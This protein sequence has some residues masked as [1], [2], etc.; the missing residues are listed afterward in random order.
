MKKEPLLC[1]FGSC[2][3]SPECTGPCAL[4]RVNTECLSTGQCVT[5]GIDRTED[6]PPHLTSEEVGF[7]ATVGL[8]CVIFALA[9][10]CALFLIV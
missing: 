6:Q 5:V 7:I 10:G 4:R 2:G 3:V 1:G 8:V 9:I